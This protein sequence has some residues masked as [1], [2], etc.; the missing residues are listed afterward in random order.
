MKKKLVGIIMGSD[1]DLEVMKEAAKAL[2]YFGIGYELTIVSAHRTPERMAKYAKE[3]EKR[4]IEVIIA[5]AGGA[6]HLPGMS[7]SFSPL[8]VIGVPIKTSALKSLDSLLSILQMPGGVPVATIAINNAKNA[9][10]LAAEILGIKYPQIR[11][12]VKK[13][14]KT[15]KRE[16]KEKAQKLERLGYKKYLI[17]EQIPEIIKDFSKNLPKFPDGRI[18]YLK[19]NIAPVMNIFVKYKDKILLSKRSNKVRVYQNKWN[20]IAG[21]LDELKPIRNKILEEV[22][23]ELGIN[24]NNVS[25]IHLSKPYKFKDREVNKTWISHPVLIE[26]KNRPKIKLNWEHTEYK[27]IRPGELKNFDTVFKLEENLKRALK[28]KQKTI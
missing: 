1:S 16:V 17:N 28:A 8:P 24:E 26:L 27:W 2:D 10:I 14:K 5:G 3:A 19:S 21:Y 4:G 18:D 13:Y 20:V 9:G 25:L 7:A 22:K 12:K 15:L 23:E 6:A 11:K